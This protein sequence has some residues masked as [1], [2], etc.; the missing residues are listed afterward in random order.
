MRL[1]TKVKRR[2]CSTHPQSS[3]GN[4]HG[5]VLRAP[6]DFSHDLCRRMVLCVTRRIVIRNGCTSVQAFPEFT[7]GVAFRLSVLRVRNKKDEVMTL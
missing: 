4:L 2:L 6:V 5:S 1:P 3:A 7:L